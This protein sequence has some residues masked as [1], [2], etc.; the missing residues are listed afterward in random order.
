MNGKEYLE[1]SGSYSNIDST[2]RWKWDNNS[3]RL[4]IYATINPAYFYH[5]M[6]A[7]LI[8]QSRAMAL[9]IQNQSHLIF[10]NLDL[11]GGKW[12]V[13]INPTVGSADHLTFK[14]CTVGFHSGQAGFYVVS[15]GTSHSHYGTISGCT[16]E[17]GMSLSYSEFGAFLSDGI[18]IGPG[19]RFWEIYDNSVSNWYHTGISIGTA[20][21]TLPTSNN[22]VHDN[23]ITSPNTTYC[24]GFSTGGPDGACQNNEIYRNVVRNT[25]VRNQI[26]GDHNLVYYNV[27]DTVRNSPVSGF[28]S[29]GQGISIEELSVHNSHHNRIYNNLIYNTDEEGLRVED[30]GA[31]VAI[32]KNEIVNNIIVDCGRSSSSFANV[33]LK[34]DN[35]VGQNIYRNNLVYASGVSEVVS[36]R[37]NSVSA[38]EFNGHNGANGDIIEDNLQDDPLFVSLS[39]RDFQI[40]EGSPCVDAGIEVGLSVDFKGTAVP[41]GDGVDVG[42]FE[43]FFNATPEPPRNFRIGH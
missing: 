33:A 29:T 5:A 28:T 30:F 41:Q 27:I 18:A 7:S 34:V 4:Y 20:Q 15:F 37:G 24:R 43:S 14:D 26:A 8:A 36:Y 17:S 21:V 25:S 39:G 1:T 2:S 23:V 16:V 3:S 10:T 6:D 42:V 12:A 32:S 35:G 11:Q 13:A 9:Q 19:C 31:G 22:R 38:V 40:L